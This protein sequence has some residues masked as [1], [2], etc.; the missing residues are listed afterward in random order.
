MTLSFYFE[1]ISAE[2][3]RKYAQMKSVGNLVP[4]MKKISDLADFE[5]CNVNLNVYGKAR[6]ALAK[7][8]F[9]KKLLARTSIFWHEV[10]LE[11][12]H[13]AI[14]MLWLG[15]CPGHRPYICSTSKYALLIDSTSI[16]L[17]IVP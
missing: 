12:P 5:E 2:L 4:V 17:C 14:F 7:F 1:P 6:G 9:F 10:T 11:P 13:E 8:L 16:K 15:K 3:A